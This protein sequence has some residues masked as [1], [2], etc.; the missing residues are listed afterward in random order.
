MKEYHKI[1]TIYKRDE[2]GN[3]LDSL[4]STP[5]IEYLKDNVWEF[6]EKIDGTNIRVMWD[7]EEIRFGGKTDNAQ[8]PAFLISRLQNLFRKEKLQFSFP[9]QDLNYPN[10][11]FYG[12]GFGA[13]IQKGGGNYIP[14]GVDFILFD[15][16][17]NGGWLKRQDIEEIGNK[18]GVRVVPLLGIGTIK[19]AVNMVQTGFNS[20]FGNFLAEG[21]V[22]KPMIQLFTRNGERI[23]TKI[24]RKDFKLS[25]PTH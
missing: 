1:N 20:T 12:E 23:V 21:I 8:I 10:I 24:K 18:L 11:C 22:L 16:W 5:E 2:K 25:R 4:F 3:I 19:D 17:V 15:I 9:V 7:G 13:R 6:T 14:N